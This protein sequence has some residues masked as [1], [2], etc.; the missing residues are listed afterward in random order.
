MGNVG[1]NLRTFK[2]PLLFNLM[3]KAS[4]IEKRDLLIVKLLTTKEI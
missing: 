2:K 1:E 4:T 3:T